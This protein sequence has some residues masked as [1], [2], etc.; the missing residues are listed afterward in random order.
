MAYTEDNVPY[1]GASASS[2]SYAEGIERTGRAEAR[3]IQLARFFFRCHKAH[4]DKWIETRVPFARG[5]ADS[6][7]VVRQARN[8]L[9]RGRIVYRYG[10]KKCKVVGVKESVWRETWLLTDLGRALMAADDI[11]SLR[12]A[13]RAGAY[14]CDESRD[15]R[16]HYYCKHCGASK[17]L[18]SK[19]TNAQD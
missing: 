1:V 2:Q 8:M 11:T 9:V 13:V 18:Q 17:R 19:G 7:A 15:H 3:Y 10:I 16:H 6:H 14:V 12:L 5:V 4:H